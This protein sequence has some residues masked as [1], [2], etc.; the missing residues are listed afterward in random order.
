[1][2]KYTVLRFSGVVRTLH[3][4]GVYGLRPWAVQTTRVERRASTIL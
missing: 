4:C 1:M 3:E 2:T